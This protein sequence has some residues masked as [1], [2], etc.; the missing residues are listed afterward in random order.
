M[1]SRLC[2]IG[3]ALIAC[4]AGCVEPVRVSDL[5]QNAP[6]PEQVVYKTA[7]AEQLKLYVFYPGGRKPANW[8]PAVVCMHGGNWLTGDPQTAFP[9]ARYFASRGVVAICVQ[10]RLAK[11][12]GPTI[13]DSLA[14]C[15]SAVRYLRA[16]AGKFGIDS[17]RI[18]AFGESAGA[19]LAACTGTI[20]DLD[21]ADEDKTISSTPNAMLLVNP[22]IDTLTFA[23]LSTVPGVKE[24][25]PD[26]DARAPSPTTLLG[27]GQAPDDRAHAISPYH[28]VAA[29]QPPALLI[30]S[31]AA[32]MPTVEDTRRLADAMQ[33]VRNQCRLFVVQGVAYPLDRCREEVY[34]EVLRA[35][36]RFL[37]SLGYVKGEPTAAASH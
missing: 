33:A 9:V 7:D 6:Q 19:H 22:F 35:C 13:F 5:K 11:P 29:G 31:A 20:K 26:K 32:D 24:L 16:N 4:A 14:D 12:Q 3:F 28:H 36:D 25:A 27:Y 2:V 37:A 23:R 8:R 17:G 10:Y 1:C 34:V 30:H 21:A 18:A 15:K